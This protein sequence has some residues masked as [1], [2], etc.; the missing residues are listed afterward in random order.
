MKTSITITWEELRQ[1][2]DLK[3]FYMGES[4]KR[5][6]LNADTMQSCKDD[7]KLMLMITQKACN[8]LITAVAVR[9]PEITCQADMTNIT[10]GF[11]TAAA[12]SSHLIAMLK[13]GIKDFLANEVCMHWL[14]TVRPEMAQ[15]NISLRSS[16][17]NNVQLTLAKIY[18]KQRIRRRPTDLAGI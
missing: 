5:N 13:Q 9:F 2:I 8:E 6:D 12:P 4:A 16:L 18:N 1:Q 7:D 14:L 17:Y 11:E 3:N 10:F 15:T